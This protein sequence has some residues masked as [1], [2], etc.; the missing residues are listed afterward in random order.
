[1][2]VTENTKMKRKLSLSLDSSKFS[3]RK[4]HVAEKSQNAFY[5]NIN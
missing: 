1:M 4:K 3:R 2:P 5:N